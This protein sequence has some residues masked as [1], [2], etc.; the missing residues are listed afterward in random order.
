MTPLPPTRVVVVVDLVV[1]VVVVVVGGRVVDVVVVVVG[2]RVVDVVV[3]VAGGRVVDVVVDVVMVVGGR[4]LVVVVLVAAGE[5]VVVVL[6]GRVVVVVVGGSVTVVVVVE[7]PADAVLWASK[8][9]CKG[10]EPSSAFT[11]SAADRVVRK[12]SSPTNASCVAN[13]VA[14]VTM[15]MPT[16]RP[17]AESRANAKSAATPPT[18]ATTSAAMSHGSN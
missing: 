17:A 18:I 4:V 6:A 3:V 9:A 2:G 15:T 8:T 12:T 10:V 7:A 13:K 14:S 5:V 16:V 11:T 1:V